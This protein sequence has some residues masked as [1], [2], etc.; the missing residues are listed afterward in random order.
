MQ[1]WYQKVI[2]AFRKKDNGDVTVQGGLEILSKLVSPELSKQTM[3]EKY[4]KSLYVF[5]CINKIAM[6]VASVPFEM[7]RIQN[8]A[9]DLKEI[10]T[11]PAL[12]LLYKVNPF[13]TKTEFLEITI[14]NLKCTGDAFWYKV[15]NN[16]GKVVELWNLRPDYITIMTDPTNFIKGYR[17]TKSDGTTVDFAPEDIIHHMYPDPTNAYLGLSPL[18]AAQKRVLTEE[19]ATQWQS[20]F[21]LNSARP[22]GLIKNKESVLTKDQKDDIRESWN[23]RH[24]GL[25]NAYKVAIL[26]GGLEYQLISLSQKEMDYIESLKFTRD[27]ILVAFQV[28]KPIVAIVD[29]V[30]RAN[31]ETA[32][33]IFLAETIKP[34]VDRLVEK[35]NEQLIYPD[36]G[37]EFFIKAVDPTPA[38]RELELKENEMGLK[39][40]YL[41]I[42]EVR[43]K[44]G[45]PPI[46]GGWS[47]YGTVAE[48]PMG[49]LSTSEQKSLY[50]KI[51]SDEKE[52]EKRITEAKTVKKFDWRG[53]FWLKQKFMIYE[54]LVESTTK[55]MSG[56]KK[57]KSTR[58]K[59]H[60]VSLLKAQESKDMYADMVN[61]AIDAKSDNLKKAA[62]VFFS[63]QKYRVLGEL[64]KKKTKESQKKLN[65]SAILK[66]DKEVGLSTEFILPF[67]EQYLKDSAQEAL[68]MIAPQ[69]DFQD[70]KR[71]QKIIQKRADFFAESVN[72]TTLEKLDK[73]LAEGIAESEGIKELMDRVET[74]YEEFPLYRCELIARTEATVAN[75]EGALEGFRQSGVATGKEWINAGDSKVRDSHENGTGV[76]GEIVPLDKSFSNGLMY[77]QEPN[78]RCVLGPA[79]LED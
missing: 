66:Y 28:P 41:L 43:A 36:F 38:N 25:K 60:F 37:D 75:N 23:K 3:L 71:I 65:G 52:N 61:K 44:E 26:E 29:D 32:M 63:G 11:H 68:N 72:S 74:V 77:P 79:F 14:I 48:I 15:R 47:F 17:M 50:K 58:K 24:G 5:A 19:Y 30:N 54:T 21:F 46:K 56:K 9:G 45:L 22:D 8:S 76:G 62:D 73:T 2:G 49:G 42:N 57:K 20:D 40:R 34:E 70:S 16:S 64:S 27:D 33:Y 51:M 31:S 10:K 39:N 6:K 69:E 12:D 78:C 35:I 4:R 18:H 13:Q 1:T 59:S 53:K 67:I 7:F 55:A